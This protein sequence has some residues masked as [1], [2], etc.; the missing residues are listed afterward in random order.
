MINRAANGAKHDARVGADG[1][2]IAK[3][4]SG[5]MGAARWL[6]A[7]LRSDSDI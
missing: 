3:R 2:G 1:L 6:S 5:P 4:L 7:L